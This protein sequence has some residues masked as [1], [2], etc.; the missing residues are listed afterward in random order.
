[1]TRN[2]KMVIEYDGTDFA[3]WQRQPA[4]VTT[5]QGEIEPVLCSVLDEE[6]TLAAAGRTDRGVHALG[7][8]ASCMTTSS[9]ELQRLH[10]ALNSL[11]PPSIRIRDVTEA[12]E[13]FHARYSALWRSYRYVLALRQSA[14]GYRFSGT[15][16]GKRPPDIDRL[17]RSA[18]LLCGT[19]DFSAFSKKGSD[20]SSTICSVMEASWS[21][22]DG[23]LV[24][25]ITANRFLRSMVRFLVSATLELGAGELS[26]ALASGRCPKAL[27]PA[28]ARGL[29]FREVGYEPDE[30]G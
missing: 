20:P 17:N 29:F 30:M 18:S 24:F 28:E 14:L 3:G 19:H 25:S 4:G 23:Q 5:V 7:Q 21:V 10:H 15:Y 12:G 22:G 2:L 8:V 13:S 16:R 11:L 26:D 27:R 1:M 6:I 9:I